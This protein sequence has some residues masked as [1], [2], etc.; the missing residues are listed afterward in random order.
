[1]F[2]PLSS[3]LEEGERVVYET[4]KHPATAAPLAAAALV[5][6]IPTYTLSIVLLA[7][8]LLQMLKHGYAVTNKKIIARQGF[9]VPRIFE[10][11][12]REISDIGVGENLIGARFG[13]G[14]VMLR[15]GRDTLLLRGLKNPESFLAHVRSVREDL[16]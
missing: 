6:A 4:N 3:F 2:S 5:L 13:M 15:G 14:S 7:F 12:L 8:P 16:S 1:L 10:I 11:P 9:I